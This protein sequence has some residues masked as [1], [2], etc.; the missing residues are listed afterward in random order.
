MLRKEQRGQRSF[1][2]ANMTLT[3]NT[4]TD[5][6]T[7]QAVTINTGGVAL[8]PGTAY[9]ALLTTSDPASILA[10]K[11][12]QGGFVF[13]ATSH[14]SNDGGGGFNY[15]NNSTKFPIELQ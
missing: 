15:Y 7:F 11:N 14:G 13:G 9:I 2:S 4:L 10:N 8:T 3:Y 12:S 6:G 1:T 5:N